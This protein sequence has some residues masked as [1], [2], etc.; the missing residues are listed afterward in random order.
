M[1]RVLKHLCYGD[2][3]KELWLFSLEERR[4]W[5]HLTAAFLPKGTREREKNCSQGHRVIGHSNGMKLKETGLD[6]MLGGNSSL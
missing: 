4:L 6:Q 3:L 2:R 1:I 5:G